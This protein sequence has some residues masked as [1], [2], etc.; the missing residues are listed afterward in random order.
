MKSRC[1]EE[2]Q[3]PGWFLSHW[4]WEELLALIDANCSD[5]FVLDGK[6][7]KKNSFVE[8]IHLV[9]AW[10]WWWDGWC[11]STGYLSL[12]FN[13]SSCCRSFNR[14]AHPLSSHEYEKMKV[15]SSLSDVMYR[16]TSENDSW[17]FSYQ[18]VFTVVVFI[19]Y[20]SHNDSS[21]REENVINLLWKW[22][23]WFAGL[24]KEEQWKTK[25]VMK[26][27]WKI[28][29]WMMRMKMVTIF[30]LVII[31]ISMIF[32][33]VSSRFISYSLGIQNRP[34]Q[35]TPRLESISLLIFK[36]MSSGEEPKEATT[37]NIH[38][39]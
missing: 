28:M 12:C 22:R 29:E 24:I 17:I 32:L 25:N 16:H 4:H 3:I 36:L 38:N 10:W 7:E 6:D 23:C 9:D 30:L 15:A 27:S 21:R 34:L 1:W 31:I 18:F 14:P 35:A 19:I 37:D 20:I 39:S 2:R 13:I 33:F 8:W 26:S 5:S 11:T